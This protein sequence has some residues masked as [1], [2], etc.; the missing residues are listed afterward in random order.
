MS[1][2]DFEKLWKKHVILV[3]I[4]KCTYGCNFQHINLYGIFEHCKLCLFDLEEEYWTHE[5]KYDEKRS[6][7][8]SATSDQNLY[9]HTN[10]IV[11]SNT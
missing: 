7:F 5:V 4:V 1:V 6:K 11:L 2:K 10:L 3:K 8:K 9:T